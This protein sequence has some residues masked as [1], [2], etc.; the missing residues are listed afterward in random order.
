MTSATRFIVEGIVLAFLAVLLLLALAPRAEAACSDPLTANDPH[1]YRDVSGV[2][3]DWSFTVAPG[4]TTAVRV[5]TYRPDRDA[6]DP[7]DEIHAQS[8][9]LTLGPG[10]YVLNNLV[11]TGRNVHTILTVDGRV[12]GIVGFNPLD[13]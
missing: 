3:V 13:Y 11:T 1:I 2:E 9:T 5:T 7:R 6:N 8:P 4:C 12:Y 10:N